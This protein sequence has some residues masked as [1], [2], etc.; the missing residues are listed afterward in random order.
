[1]VAVIPLSSVAV[2]V[3]I[4]DATLKRNHDH[5]EGAGFLSKRLSWHEGLGRS[6]VVVN[7]G[8]GDVGVALD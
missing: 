7:L 3:G 8:V 6:R 5:I 4:G 2:H 1:M